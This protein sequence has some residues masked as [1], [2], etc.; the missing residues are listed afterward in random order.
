MKSEKEEGMLVSAVLIGKD[1]V[2]VEV[3]DQ[4]QEEISGKHAIVVEFLVIF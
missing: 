4:I 2:Q 3:Q 1:L